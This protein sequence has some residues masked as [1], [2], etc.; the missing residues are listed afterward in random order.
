M[1]RRFEIMDTNTREYRRYNDVGR[2]IT[3]RLIPPSDN[4]DPETHFIA[5]VNDLIVHA[6]RDVVHSD[7][8]GITI[9]SQVNLNDKP[10]GISFRRKDQSPSRFQDSTP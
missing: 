2:Q 6:L 3:A 1:V 7:M 5:S 9:Q 10:N 4:S 8:V